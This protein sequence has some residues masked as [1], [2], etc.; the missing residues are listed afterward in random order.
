[1]SLTDSLSSPGS[2]AYTF[3]RLRTSCTYSDGHFLCTS[4]TDFQTLL[5]GLDVAL[6]PPT[7]DY[8][9]RLH[10]YSSHILIPM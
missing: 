4:S 10:L 1:M 3:Y 6:G 5:L 8:A 7:Y 2:L 9:A